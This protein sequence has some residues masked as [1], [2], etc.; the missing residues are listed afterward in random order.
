MKG[1]VNTKKTGAY[2]VTFSAKDCNGKLCSTTVSIKVVDT[3]KPVFKGLGKL[4]IERN[5]EFSPLKKVSARMVSGKKLKK[6][7][8]EVSG[9]VNTGVV[10]NYRITYKVKG[11][12]GKVRKRV[13]VVKVVDTKAPVISGLDNQ[14]LTGIEADATEEQLISMII[15]DITNRINVTDNGEEYTVIN[16][17]DMGEK[18]LNENC[19]VDIASNGDGQFI[20]NVIVKDKYNNESKASVVYSIQYN[21]PQTVQQTP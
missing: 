5:A 4:T 17:T 12:N 18:L 2:K 20:A 3:K 9:N 10:G 8:I 19:T 21:Q 16:L 6:N 1:N 7:S 15:K 14:T 13:R 11:V